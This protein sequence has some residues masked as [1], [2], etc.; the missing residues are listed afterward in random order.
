[1]ASDHATIIGTAPAPAE[2]TPL[3]AMSS[4]NQAS[5]SAGTSQGRNR[6]RC[7]AR[8]SE[9]DRSDRGE[10]EPGQVRR[11]VGRY[12]ARPRRT[13]TIQEPP[14]SAARPSARGVPG[15]GC[16]GPN[17]TYDGGGH[18][19]RPCLAVRAADR[20]GAIDTRK[21]FWPSWTPEPSAGRRPLL[22]AGADQPD[23]GDLHRTPEVFPTSTHQPHRHQLPGRVHLVS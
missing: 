12:P 10:Q 7:V 18:E 15:A 1:M 5:S 21:T 9:H 4:G 11:D 13:R 19:N 3:T 16:V 23:D 14:G 20:V 2:S 17:L 8:R 22:R 6:Q